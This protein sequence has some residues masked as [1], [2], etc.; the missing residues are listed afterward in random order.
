MLAFA[1]AVIF[2]LLALGFVV[3]MAL[4]YSLLARLK[5]HHR[6]TWEQLGEPT[7]VINN[8]IGAFLATQ[9]FLMRK[10]YARLGDPT[11]SSIGRWLTAVQAVYLAVF[12]VSVIFV[13]AL[14]L[15]QP[16]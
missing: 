3:G 11:L 16:A 8:S 4:T 10:E 1:P 13:G 2:G 5:S 12:L 9:R 7:L 15:S 6:A 14:I